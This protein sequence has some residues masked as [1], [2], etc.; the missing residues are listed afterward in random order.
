MLHMLGRMLV[1]YYLPACWSALQAYSG[2]G[3]EDRAALP[4][5]GMSMQEIGRAAA[6]AWGLA[7]PAV[8]AMRKVEPRAAG[9]ALEH[10]KW[11]AALSTMSAQ[12]ADALWHDDAAGVVA[13]R[14]L[15]RSFSGMLGVAPDV[16]MA[17]L[18]TAREVAAAACRSRRW[19]ARPRAGPGRWPKRACG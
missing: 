13:V 3:A 15:A 1:S 14:A 17:A 16:I 12:C 9:D 10:D 4:V 8:G 5:M 7:A 2:A 6:L 18:E 19:R 11:L